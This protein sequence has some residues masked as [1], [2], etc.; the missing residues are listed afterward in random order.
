MRGSSAC[1]WVCGG[2]KELPCSPSKVNL[3]IDSAD[4]SESVC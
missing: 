2:F 3:I 1:G 4:L